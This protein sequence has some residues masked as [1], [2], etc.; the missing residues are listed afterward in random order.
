MAEQEGLEPIEEQE[1]GGK[2][3]KKLIIIVAGVVV[4]L[5]VVVGALFA[6]GIIGG[7]GQTDEM[8]PPD[9]EQPVKS[10]DPTVVL[11]TVALESFVVNLADVEQ[12]RFLKVTIVI[13]LTQ[14][15][16][17]EEVEKRKQKIKDA[18]IT[19]LSS[20]SVAQVRDSKGKLKLKQEITL[21]LNEILGTNSVSEVLFTQF[22][23]S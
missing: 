16:V 10:A 23:I 3:K 18:V 13:E 12:T 15:D 6:F 9:A 19:L 4:L 1:G 11:P 20:K 22:I 14:E 21:R 8:A 7:G 2:S 5:G 17:A